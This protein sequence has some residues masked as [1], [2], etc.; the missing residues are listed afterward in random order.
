M[1][2]DLRKQ[3]SKIDSE[4]ITLLAKRMELS[5]QIGREKKASD[6]EIH[7]KT[8]EMAVLDSVKLLA[9]SLGLSESVVTDIFVVIFAES[10]RLQSKMEV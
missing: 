7:Q 10:R 9:N 8:R 5:V 6:I 1:I 4:L 2:D 3:V